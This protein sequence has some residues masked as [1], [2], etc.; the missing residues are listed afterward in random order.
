[1]KHLQDTPWWICDPE[2]ENYCAYVDTDSNYFHAEPLLRHRFPNFDEMSDRDKD[3]KLKEIALEYQDIITKHYDNIAK[4]VFNIDQFEWFDKPHWLEMKTECVIRSAYFRATRRYAQWITVEE[5][6]ELIKY[7][8]PNTLNDKGT[9]GSDNGFGSSV[10][11]EDNS[12]L[13]I[14]GLE[15]QKAN[16][17]P[18]LGEFFYET[19]VDVLK[20][21]TQ[22]EIDIRV[23]EFKK[24]IID[25]TIPLSELGNP[26]SV[27]QINKHQGK[28]ARAGEIFSTFKEV[29]NK[30]DKKLGAP[31]AVKAAIRY[32]DLL[33]FW[34]LD[35]KH[36]LIAQGE[37]IKWVYLKPNP[38]Q[39]E[40]LAF[41]EYDIPEKI[42][43]FLDEYADREKIFDSILLNKLEGF[44]S[45][46]EWNLNLNPYINQFFEL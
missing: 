10:I 14:K 28:P 8:N 31:A 12:K 20:G 37:K 15:F 34:K 1:M 3:H 44:Y 2:D 24:K 38:Y 43:T 39:I 41:L 26:T 19:L 25:G 36:N 40:E 33:R 16:F 5:G 23:K 21:E 46:L 17:P 4:D 13:D 6:N 7:H 35:G 22:E 30:A 45:D 18:L 9:V 29:K 27:K 32:N 42:R 11:L